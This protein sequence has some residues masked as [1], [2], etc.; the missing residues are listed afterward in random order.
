[1]HG[2]GEGMHGNC[3]SVPFDSTSLGATLN[4]VSRC[5]GKRNTAFICSSFKLTYPY[6][7]GGMYLYKASLRSGAPVAQWVKASD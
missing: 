1:M 3:T 7:N 5:T 2:N 6:N 4:G